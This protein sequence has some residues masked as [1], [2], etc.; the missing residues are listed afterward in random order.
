MSTQTAPLA[1]QGAAQGTALRAAVIGLG[2]M[3]FGMAQSLRRAGFDVAGTD[4]NP[5]AVARFAA[6]GGRGA[7]S[8]AE[9]AADASVVVCV[10][11]NAAQTE[12][13]LF[14]P[15]GVAAAMPEGAVFVS[16]ATMDPAVARRLAAGLEATGRHYL[17]API[18][19]G[20]ARAAK[21]E[22]TVMASGTQAA[23]AAAR[24]A[25][26]AMA[27]TVHELGDAAGIGASFKMINQLLAGVHIAAAG[28]AVALAAKLGL[29]LDK[30]Y[31]VITG[32]AGNSW[33]F[34]NR[35]PH[36]LAGDYRPLSA[37]EIFV[38]DLGIVQDM[39]RAERFPAPIAAAA[40]QMYL[41]SAGLGFGR[42]D[43][44]SVARTYAQLSGARLPQP[45][46]PAE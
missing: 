15:G 17:D 44:S 43:D 27:A 31:E 8:P 33:M 14:G 19:G 4:V 10:V 41:A 32:S 24:A 39:V 11:V 34:E 38:K 18:S 23:F 46:G 22:L 30:V 28:E 29:D 2:S 3:G 5:D 21:G 37:I 9:A 20:A 35:V 6:E 13:V 7:A 16:S 1:A 25:L 26:D 45:G 40:L 36:I 42:D 12:A